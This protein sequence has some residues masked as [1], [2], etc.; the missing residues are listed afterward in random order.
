MREEGSTDDVTLQLLEKARH[1]LEA[2]AKIYDKMQNGEMEDMENMHGETKYLVDFH[3][4]Y[5]TDVDDEDEWLRKTPLESPNN[6]QV[7]NTST[8]SLFE[9]NEAHREKMREKW[10]KEQE[11]LLDGAVHY[12]HV[13]HDEVRDLGTGYF[14]FSKDEEE[15]KKQLDDLKNMREET[16]SAQSK[17]ELLKN[18]RKR[19][20]ESRLEKVKRRKLGYPDEEGKDD[21]DESSN[22]ND[23]NDFSADEKPSSPKKEGNNVCND[24]SPD[25]SLLSEDDNNTLKSCRK[26][27]Q[28]ERDWDQ[29]K[30]TGFLNKIFLKSKT[31]KPVYEKLIEERRTERADDFA[32]P[33]SY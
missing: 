10:E 28:Q 5:Y 21:G 8:S 20:L 17:K 12:E 9:A 4:K 11:E 1:K 19:A 29:G 14:A 26:Q 15:R 24:E 7:P 22:K 18:K 32:P 31:L 23:A 30:K 6:Q 13:K 16:K 33:S 2:K 3:H 25:N 27:S